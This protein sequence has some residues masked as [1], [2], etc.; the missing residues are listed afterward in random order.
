VVIERE[1]RQIPLVLTAEYD[2]EQNAYMIGITM[3]LSEQPVRYGIARAAVYSFQTM[4]AVVKELLEFLFGLVTQGKGAGD[5]ASPIGIVTV[6][7]Q[8][9]QQYGLQSF[10]SIAIFLSV[11]LGLFNLLPLPALD[12]S[13]VIFLA[14][15]GIRRKPVP[16]EKEGIITAVGFGLFILLFIFL[17]GRDI[18]RLFGWVT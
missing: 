12:G 10:I 18:A 4:V 16:P 13:K 11:N 6:M 2:K 1:G 17:A 15:E 3:A 14:I 7:T 9:A 5:V 8:Q